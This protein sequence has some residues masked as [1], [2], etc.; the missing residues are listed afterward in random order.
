MAHS[1]CAAFEL[2]IKVDLGGRK[3]LEAILYRIGLKA[4]KLFHIALKRLS[5]L[6]IHAKLHLSIGNGKSL[7]VGNET[8]SVRLI[9]F[10][11]EHNDFVEA[12][13]LFQ[14]ILGR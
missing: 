12:Q 8:F 10:G 4:A 7:K 6:N 5:K 9:L 1:I 3:A 13:E 2:T 14:S 11:N